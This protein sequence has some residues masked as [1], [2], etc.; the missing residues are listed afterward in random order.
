[1]AIREVGTITSAMTALSWQC[2]HDIVVVLRKIVLRSICFE[3]PLPVKVQDRTCQ[4]LS[5]REAGRRTPE[6]CTSVRTPKTWEFVDAK[7]Q[8]WICLSK[9]QGSRTCQR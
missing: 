8:S 4:T 5:P 9:T 2:C 3:Q 1:M 6:N 7:I